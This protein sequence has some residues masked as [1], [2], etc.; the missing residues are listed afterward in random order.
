MSN[1]NRPNK[2]LRVAYVIANEDLASPLLTRQ[3]VELLSEAVTQSHGSLDINLLLFQTI[4][5]LV[6]RRAQLR[7]L[8]IEMQK[9]RLNLSIIPNLT[10]WPFPNLTLQRTAL[11]WRPNGVWNRFSARAFKL[12]AFPFLLYHYLF[13]R[14]RIFHSRSYPPAVAIH[15][16]KKLLPGVK[17]VF[18]P[19]SD[20]PEENVVSG[21]WSASS[22]DFNFWKFTEAMIIS[23]ANT[24]VCISEAYAQHF[25]ESVS[26]FEYIVAPNNVDTERF[27]YRREARENIRAA[28]GWSDTDLVFVYLGGMSPRG[29]H[30]PEFYRQ[31]LDSIREQDLSAKLLMLIPKHALDH[32][33]AVFS[34]THGVEIR[35]VGYDEVPV[36]LS[37][38]DVGLMFMH[39]R[40]LAVGT[41]ISEY[42]SVGLPIACNSNCLGTV[43]FLQ[44]HPNAGWKIGLGLGDL[45]STID[46]AS[47][48]SLLGAAGR[49]GD[50][51]SVA[52]RVFSNTTVA[53]IYLR[54]YR[55]L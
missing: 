42:L 49:R 15:A 13:G 24:T 35:H 11:G 7:D 43:R 27:S 38:A 19:R 34:E 28:L 18:D 12:Y 30:R 5:S 25:A 51:R 17:H 54:L 16:L 47:L 8:K 31:L 4:P 33:R 1:H 32:T 50:L 21:S 45:D 46:S 52:E 3:V 55:T 37:A 26:G 2:P 9:N 6:R 20:F 10:P 44:D 40:R 48:V 22:R 53:Q 39:K 41:K 14:R 29:W 36:W 23:R